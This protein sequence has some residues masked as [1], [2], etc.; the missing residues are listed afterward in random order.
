MDVQALVEQ[1]GYTAVFLGTFLEGETVLVLAG[2]AAHRGYLDV[3]WVMAAAFAG[4]VAGD[5]LYFFLGRVHGTALLQR[6]PDWVARVQRGQQLLE[7]HQIWVILGFRF[8]Y[9]LRTVTPLAIGLSRVSA[10]RFAIL[11]LAGAA[12]WSVGVAGAGYAFGDLMQLLL[13]DLHHYELAI[14][15]AIAGAGMLAWLGSRSKARSVRPVAPDGE[16]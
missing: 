2:F 6:H 9:G 8:L 7:R 16:G 11:N 10:A 5:Q 1:Y 14:L 3:G 15:L 13:G 12:L 4:S